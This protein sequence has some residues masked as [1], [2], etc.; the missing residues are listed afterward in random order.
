MAERNDDVEVRTRFDGEWVPGYEV[1]D[2]DTP[3]PRVKVRRR[4]D[5]R[6]LPETFAPDEVR[7]D[8]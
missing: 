4:S 2:D 3:T 8:R 5:G 1:V 7:P 6:V